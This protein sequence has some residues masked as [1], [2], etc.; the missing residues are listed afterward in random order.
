MIY[1]GMD[2]DRECPDIPAVNPKTAINVPFFGQEIPV[3]PGATHI[4]ADKNGAVHCYG[5]EP[6]YYEWDCE[7]LM[8]FANSCVRYC[9]EVDLE[10][11]D[12]K[13]TC[14]EIGNERSY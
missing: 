8:S 4:A 14:M 3:D 7:W 1:L 10:G 13:E 2:L 12:W 9:G 5:A 6:V 11:M